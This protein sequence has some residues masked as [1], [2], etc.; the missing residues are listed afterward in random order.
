[1]PFNNPKVFVV[2]ILYFKFLTLSGT[3]ED[4]LYCLGVNWLTSS[5]MNLKKKTNTECVL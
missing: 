3:K 5:G 2:V 1:M 4:Q